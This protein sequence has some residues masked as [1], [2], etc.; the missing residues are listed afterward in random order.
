MNLEQRSALQFNLK[1]PVNQEVLSEDDAS[2]MAKLKASRIRTNYRSANGP[3]EADQETP[4]NKDQK[5][6]SLCGTSYSY[7]NS[8]YG[9]LEYTY[10]SYFCYYGN[11][12]YY[13][14]SYYGPSTDFPI[15]V[16]TPVFIIG[17]VIVIF[18]TCC[19]VK[20]CTRYKYK[21][22]VAKL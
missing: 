6:R 19:V 12:Y 5:K 7:Y 11:Y 20:I 3:S 8:Y 13:G 4:I 14:F 21:N 22:G 15:Q 17:G 10:D 1:M 16:L 9:T 2:T 18:M